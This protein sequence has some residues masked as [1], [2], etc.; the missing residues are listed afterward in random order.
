MRAAVEQAYA[1]GPDDKVAAGLV[2]YL[3]RH[4]REEEGH[5]TWLLQDL[6]ATGNDPREPL[7]RIPPPSVAVLVGAQYYWLRHYHPVSILGHIAALE[8]YHPPVGFARQ[9]S[10][11]T[12]YPA[13]AFRAIARHEVLDTIHARELFE[14]VDALSLER[15]HETL[16]G[17]S[18]LH[19]L[20]A[21]IDVLEDI[22]AHVAAVAGEA[23]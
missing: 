5:D 18:A 23:T 3:T 7:S 9:L 17:V 1:R 2:E 14:V 20:S 11:Q 10:A 15:A 22:Y 6:E 8:S 21:G 19:T 4:M 12:G 13:T 16:I